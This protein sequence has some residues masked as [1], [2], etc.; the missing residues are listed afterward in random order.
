MCSTGFAVQRRQNIADQHACLSRRAAGFNRDD[1]QAPS[2]I[3]R[4]G[5]LVG[6]LGRLRSD[7]EKAGLNLALGQQGSDRFAD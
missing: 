7:A 1:E 4:F 5:D 2:L 3:E 6:Q